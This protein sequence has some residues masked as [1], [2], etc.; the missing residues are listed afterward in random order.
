I[1][2]EVLPPID[3]VGIFASSRWKYHIPAMDKPYSGKVAVK[4]QGSVG[5]PSASPACYIGVLHRRKSP[6][7]LA[8]A[9]SKKGW[10]H[11][12]KGWTHKKREGAIKG[13]GRSVG[14]FFVILLETIEPF[15]RSGIVSRLV[16]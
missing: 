7:L 16:A 1:P 2:V 6:L 14:K 13:M 12:E 10:S 5:V 8:K 15:L 9:I 11:S 4:L 3:P